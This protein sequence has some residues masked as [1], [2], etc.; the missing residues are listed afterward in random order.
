M[1]HCNPLTPESGCSAHQ[2]ILSAR[3]AGA[4]PGDLTGSV[5]PAPSSIDSSRGGASWATPTPRKSCRKPFWRQCRSISMASACTSRAGMTADRPGEKRRRHARTSR[6]GTARSM[7]GTPGAWGCGSWRSSSTFPPRPSPRFFA[8]EPPEGEK[9]ATGQSRGAF[10]FHNR[11]GAGRTHR[12][13]V[14]P[15]QT[16]TE[17]RP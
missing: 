10:L 12:S 7:P 4:T 6:P 8:H 3:S 9:S 15:N 5:A 14:F 17:T 11:P 13:R 2:R 1:S 16:N